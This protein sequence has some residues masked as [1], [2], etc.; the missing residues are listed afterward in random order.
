MAEECYFYLMASMRKMRLN[1]PLDYTLEFFENL[2]SEKIIQSG[3]AN[4]IVTFLVYR[5]PSEYLNKAQVSYC[6]SVENK[7]VLK[8]NAAAEIDILK[9]INVNTHLLSNIHVHCPENI[10][11]QIYAAENDLDDVIL[12]N[13]QKRIARCSRGNLV[14]LENAS[15]KI[16]KQSEGAYIS[17]LLEHFVT[18]LHR[19]GQVQ[20]EEV[21]MNAFESQKADEVLIV[22]DEHGLAPVHK[23]RN[24]TFGSATVQSMIAGWRQ[25]FDL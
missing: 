3:A 4:G 9:E 17:P 10:Y 11:A 21:E 14:F 7:D 25:S 13:P 6:F 2:F 18:Y 20:I 15:L 1:I 23:I 12:L 24:K 8:E 22:S 19:H 16:P 5:T